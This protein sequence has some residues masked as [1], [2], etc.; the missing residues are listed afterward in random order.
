MIK[1]YSLI[2]ILWWSS[3]T[4]GQI[5]LTANGNGN[6]LAQVLAGN[7]VTISNV[8]INCPGT[9]AGTFTCSNC[10]LGMQQ[11]VVLT[12]GNI[13]LVA[14]P[15]NVGSAGIDNFAPGDNQLNGLAGAAT[16]DACVLEFDL[17]VLGDSVE[18]RYVFGSEEY[19][20]WVSAGFNDA[21]AFYISGPGIAGQ[22]NIAL[23]PGTAVPVT[24]DNVNNFSY[25]QYYV[26]NGTGFSAPQNGSNY[27]IQYDGFTTVL[28]AKQKNLQPCQTYHLKLVVAD[29]GDGIYDSGVFLEANSLISNFVEVEDAT[30][31]DPNVT[32]GVEG[33]ISGSI[34][35]KLQT[36]VPT[37]TTVSYTIG[38]SATNGVDYNNLSGTIT[39]PANDTMATLTINPVSDGLVEGTERLVIYLNSPCNN[40]PYDSAVLLIID[41]LIFRAGPDTTIC[42]GQSVQLTAD[43]A[44]T[45]N[46]TPSGSLSAANIRNPIATP[47]VTTTYLC[48]ASYGICSVSDSVK[49]TII[50]APFN[51]NAGPDVINCTGSPV[52]LNAS[53][54]GPTVG[55][56]P[57][58]FSWS[59]AQ[60]LS[61][62]NT[63]AVTANPATQTNYIVQVSS[64]G[65]VDYD[66]VRVQ[67]GNVAVTASATPQTCFGI[68]NG[69]VSATVTTGNLPY[70]YAWSNNALSATQTALAPGSYTVTV[71]DGTS[72]TAT[73]QTVVSAANAISFSNP[74][75]NNVSCNGTANGSV[76]ITATGGS[77]ITGY[78]WSNAANT[79]SITNLSGGTYAVT[80]TDASGCTAST[81][82]VV[83]E[84]T[85]L[86]ANISSTNI[87]CY[88]AQTGTASVA[89]TG[90]TTPY[91]YLWSNSATSSS[92]SNMSAALYSVTVTDAN[93]CTAT[94]AANITQPASP[95]S[96]TVNSTNESCYGAQNGTANVSAGGGTFP[97]NYLW[98]NTQT[99]SSLT[100]LSPGSYAVTVTD[101]NGCTATAATGVAAALPFVFTNITKTDVKCFG[102]NTGSISVTASGGAGISG[103][104][105]NTGTV[106]AA[107]ASLSAGT[108]TV[109]AIDV[110]NC[111]IDTVVLI[112]QPTLL[113]AA[114]TAVDAICY[115]ANNGTATCTA[116]GGVTP[117]QYLWNTGATTSF[118]GNLSPGSYTITVTDANSC[119]ANA[120]STVYEPIQVSIAVASAPPTC[121]YTA[122][123]TITSTVISGVL[124]FSFSLVNNN[125]I[126]SANTSGAFSNLSAGNYT[127]S[128][129]DADGCQADFPI[130]I[131]P[132]YP[133]EFTVTT[134]STSCYGSDYNDGSISVNVLST[135]NQPYYFSLDGGGNQLSPQF[136]FVSAGLHTVTV[137]NKNGCVSDTTVLVPE[138]AEG[139]VEIFP[140]D[141]TIVLG[142]QL[143]L[144]ALLAPYSASDVIAYVWSPGEGLSC[145]DC[146]APQM[147]G[148]VSNT[149]GVTVTYYNNCTATATQKVIVIDE[150][151]VFIPNGFSP[152]GDGNNDV[153]Y[154][155][156]KHILTVDLKIFDRWGEEVFSS[157]NQ[158]FAGWDGTYKSVL[159]PPAV[160]TYV[161]D[162]TYLNGK[163]KQHK[164]TVTILR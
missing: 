93:F 3:A 20:E 101:F 118:I 114:V 27:Y 1:H 121:S 113:Q 14:G 12:S 4:Y 33:C 144:P 97:Y 155:Y 100:N 76:S 84:P 110:N 137:I 62:T 146:A 161:A 147:N 83:T 61:A 134:D 143:V 21:F 51:V 47:A 164:G 81:T 22:Q 103:Y 59:P 122:D 64:G 99:V 44:S 85:V 60:G 77:G 106:T 90:G 8:T 141:T 131:L 13:N 109:T 54:S 128:V 111:A 24:I 149:Y 145:N 127:V 11:G 72:C 135:I 39:I 40:Q 42:N 148:Y 36:P 2:L 71:T 89:V 125:S 58:V 129:T 30:T 73:A 16:Y 49:V 154:V 130:T 94:L 152:N 9:S 107:L 18:F 46:W 160:Y 52:P 74:V 116:Q 96:I 133:D 95:L 126:V 108:Y 35:F 75:V 28:T 48:Q 117:Y 102:D 15:N 17:Q 26:N 151:P 55:G 37:P 6:Q 63:A 98:S 91:N 66:T 29:A 25:S 115:A 136:D 10:N 142:D 87:P 104:I 163:K 159:Q 156:G 19:L 86:S 80:A 43:F 82:V 158:A 50:S 57:F 23:I 150:P 123:G 153:F 139:F 45:Y 105:W 157:L 53:V 67:V 112:L 132:P 65:C 119:T 138:P 32:N 5:N 38:G 69:T 34:K 88:G 79:N 56:N 162:V 92:I 70:S 120:G 31:S 140:K 68:N 78:L 41:S 124:P 7:G